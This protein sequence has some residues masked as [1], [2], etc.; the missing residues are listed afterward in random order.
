MRKYSFDYVDF[1]ASFF[2]APRNRRRDNTELKKK[3]L[4]T[5]VQLD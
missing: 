4:K 1:K 5:D 3:D 2:Y